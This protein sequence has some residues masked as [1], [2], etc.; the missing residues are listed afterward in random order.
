MTTP[1]TEPLPDRQTEYLRLGFEAPG[2]E[3]KESLSWEDREQRLRLIRTFMAMSN[4]RDGGAA[5]VGVRE[6]ADGTFTPVGMTRADYDSLV[7]DTIAAQTARYADPPPDMRTV[8]G[9]HDGRLFVV[10]EV[11]P[12]ADTPTVCRQVDGGSTVL[13][14]GAV[15]VRP[16]G[17]PRT[18]EI[19]S[20]RDMRDIIEL[21]VERRIQRFRELG[22]LPAATG[23]QAEANREALDREVQDLL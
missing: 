7:P 15:Y 10:V 1:A 12:F 19:H 17:P 11:E 23:E 8:K 9:E 4:M 14:E 18:E 5:V 21:A 22:L 6:N 13:R 2:L 20:Y 3:F 16:A